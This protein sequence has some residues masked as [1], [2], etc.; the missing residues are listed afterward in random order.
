M[1]RNIQI[2]FLLFACTTCY[3]QS[4]SDFY[5]QTAFSYFLDNI[6][7]KD[8]PSVKIAYFDK[9]INNSLSFLRR[10]VGFE[11]YTH[12]MDSNQVLEMDRK[13]EIARN[14]DLSNCILYSDK[15]YT[16]KLKDIPTVWKKMNLKRNVVIFLS[17]RLSL[18][19]GLTIVELI[20]SHNSTRAFYY[21]EIDEDRNVV[22]RWYNVKTYI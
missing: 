14:L 2:F 19:K 3:G 8:Y 11:E 20:V 13:V 4:H 16:F 12:R 1:K 9:K 21:F 10:P 5:E 18:H 17:K 22:V 7:I 15:T 6:I